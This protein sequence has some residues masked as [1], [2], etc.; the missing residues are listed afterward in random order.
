MATHSTAKSLTFPSQHSDGRIV[1]MRRACGYVRVSTDIQ[2]AFGLSLD[3]QKE[4]ITRYAQINNYEMIG[5]FVD[6]DSAK[7]VEGRPEYVKMIK[8]IDKGKA[9]FIIANA[10]DRFSRSQRD[11]L[12]FQD[13]YIKP[14]KVHLILIKETINT[15]QPSTTHFLNLLVT[16][17]QMEREQ[18]S[19]RVKGIIGYIRSQGGHF[20]KVPFG[21]MAVSEG[22]LK[23]LAPHPENHAWLERMKEWYKQ[24]ICFSDIA[25]KLNENGV[26][27]SQALQWTQTSVYDLLVKEGTHVLRS[28]RGTKI[29]DK[30]RA[31]K[32]AYDLRE[33][34]RTFGFIADKLNKEGLRPGK[35]EE[36]KWYSVQDLL[37]SAVYHDRSMPKGCAK[38]WHAQGKSL[39]DIAIK[40]MENGHK[41][42][43]GSDQWFAQQVKQLL[44]D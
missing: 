20:G 41:T 21:Y 25:A 37:R 35:A 22:R 9:Q 31:H 23:K 30:E 17:A 42:K 43:R 32:I 40:L 12:N 19:Q 36:Y 11:F 14:G 7:N 3:A 6:H 18:T 16:F 8:E 4:Q 29:F 2:F 28:E 38:Y 44:I 24:E 27:P 10:L 33:D 15:E 13:D 5:F 34:G 1:G 26:K 39:R